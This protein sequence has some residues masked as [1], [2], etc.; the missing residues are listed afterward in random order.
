MLNV[1]LIPIWGVNG[2]AIASLVTQIITNVVLC[3]VVHELQPTVGLMKDSLNI[4]LLYT[5]LMK[6]D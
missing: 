3:F 6:R 5:A 1:L 4:K 2:A